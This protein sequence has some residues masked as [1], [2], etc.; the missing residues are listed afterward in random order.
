MGGRNNSGSIQLYQVNS[1]TGRL[2]FVANATQPSPEADDEFGH[3]VGVSGGR[4]V[5]SAPG[6][7]VGAFRAGAV[8]FYSVTYQVWE[9]YMWRLSR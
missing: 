2:D 7:T 9:G 4:V 5:A 1:V 3:A 6:R 8:F